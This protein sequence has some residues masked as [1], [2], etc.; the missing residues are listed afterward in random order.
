MCC[1]PAWSLILLFAAWQPL[2]ATVWQAADPRAMAA[3]RSLS[4]LGWLIVLGT[5]LTGHFKLLERKQRC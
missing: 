1:A 5:F 2:P 4:A 3:I